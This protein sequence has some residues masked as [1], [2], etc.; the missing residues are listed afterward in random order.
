M[1]IVGFNDEIIDLKFAKNNKNIILMAT[2]SSV[3]KVFN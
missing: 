1:N 3:L 2:N